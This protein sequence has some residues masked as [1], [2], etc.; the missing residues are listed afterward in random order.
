MDGD[1]HPIAQRLR[2]SGV[3]I[4]TCFITSRNLPNPRSLL[5]PQDHKEFVE[6][7]GEKVLMQMS[8]SMKNNHTPVSYLINANWE[9]PISGESYLFVQANSLDVVNEFCRIVV[10]Q[11]TNRTCDALIHLVE[12]VPLATYINQTNVAFEPRT[13]QGQTCY[14][15][16]TATVFHLAMH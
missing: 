5:D 6:G 1:P 10:S 12:K 3:T 15:C 16:A 7:S 14:A 9:L 2:A 8:S 13:Q 11:L 4:A